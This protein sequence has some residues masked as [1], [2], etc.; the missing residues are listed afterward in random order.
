MQGVNNGWLSLVGYPI[1]PPYYLEA[2]RW[3]I[4]DNN[5]LRKPW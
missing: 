3:N 4:Y 2:Y 5:Q 1:R